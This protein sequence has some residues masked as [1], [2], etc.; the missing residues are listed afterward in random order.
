MSR[1]FLKRLRAIA[2]LA[3]LGAACGPVASTATERQQSVL[4][5][6]KPAL[7]TYQER[8]VPIKLDAADFYRYGKPDRRLLDATPTN[9]DRR[10]LDA[11]RG[12]W[13][14]QGRDDGRKPKLETYRNP[15]GA[16][17]RSLPRREGAVVEGYDSRP[18]ATRRSNSFRRL[19]EINEVSNGRESRLIHRIVEVAP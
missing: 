5:E 2:L 4:D 3:V 10:D 17:G 18:D 13:A 9:P 15:P 8:R 11:E 7:T 16:Q 1:K 14:R 6:N 12:S 19:E